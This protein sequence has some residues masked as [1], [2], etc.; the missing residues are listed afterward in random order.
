MR[1]NPHVVGI[2][3]WN[4]LVNLECLVGVGHQSTP[5]TSL[6]LVHTARRSYRLGLLASS[7]EG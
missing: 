4:V 3:D 2:V 6:P 5:D 1:S 7:W